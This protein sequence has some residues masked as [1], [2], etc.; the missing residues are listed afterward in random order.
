MAN[1]DPLPAEHHVTRCCGD[2]GVDNGIVTGAAFELRPK[3]NGKLSVD[4]V[5]CEY[6]AHENQNV[7]GSKSRL[8]SAGLRPQFI[9]VLNVG[10][11]R[12]VHQN[13][14][15]L[16][17]V[18]AHTRNK[19]HSAIIGMQYGHED[20]LTQDELADLVNDSG[21]IDRLG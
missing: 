21:T 2:R 5:E 12:R 7:E 11:I 13:N 8:K 14:R 9:A 1:G 3:D 19:C 6:V 18:E 16:D 17:V 20:L 15:H 4:W 10:D